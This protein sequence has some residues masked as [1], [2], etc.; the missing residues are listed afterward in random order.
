MKN[1]KIIDSYNKIEPN[2]EVKER[3]LKN[4]IAASEGKRKVLSWKPFVSAAAAVVLLS[5]TLYY[6]QI[7]SPNHIS[8]VIQED[9]DTTPT[10][11]PPVKGDDLSNEVKVDDLSNEVKGLPVKNFTIIDQDSSVSADRIAFFNLINLFENDVNSFV[12][13]K[14][15]EVEKLAAVDKYS[16][17]GQ[18]STVKVLDTIWGEKV[19]E[20]IDLQQS[21]YGGCT[22]EE[23]TNLLREGGV[24]LLPLNKYNGSYYL[25]SDLD[26]L[27]EIDNEGL[28]WSHSAYEDFNRFD[29]KG[30]QAVVDEIISITQDDTVMLAA[31]RFGMTLKGFQLA[32]VTI[33]SEATEEENEYGYAEMVYNAKVESTLSGDELSSEISIRSYADENLILTNGG[34]YLLFVDN[35]ENKHFINTGM[36]AQVNEDGKIQNLG[37]NRGSFNEYNGYTVAEMQGLTDMVMNYLSSNQE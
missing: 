22:G 17:E 23:E 9:K 13:V 29:G 33:L 30:Y 27:F 28:I 26:V 16:S 15:G 10:D 12:I 21:L 2:S 1:K 34:R 37:D 5:G 4:I 7:Y 11:Q 18:I 24:Y 19:P 8:N 35:Y 36:I 20:V 6:T 31:S 32:E 25:M 14:V 3:M